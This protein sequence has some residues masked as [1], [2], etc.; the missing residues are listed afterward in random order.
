MITR[1]EKTNELIVDGTEML[2]WLAIFVVTSA[3]I[4]SYIFT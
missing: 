2:G 4:L 1:N 3:F